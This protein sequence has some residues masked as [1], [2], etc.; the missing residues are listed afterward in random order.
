MSLLNKTR[1]LNRLLQKE[2]GNAVSFMDMAEVLRDIVIANIYV[3]SRKGKILGY[4]TTND[5]VS[6]EMNQAIL[7]ERRFPSESNN[8]LLKIEETTSTSEPSSP[9]YYYTEQMKD[10]FPYTHTT[11]VP[12]IGG[13]DRLGTLILSR[14]ESLFIDD[15]LILA[16]YG[17][18]VIAMEIL[19]E[20]AEEIEEEARSKAVVQVAIGSLSFSEMEAVEHIFEELDGKEG[21]LVASKIADRVGITRSVIV[22]ALRKLESAGVIETRSLGMKG[23]YIRILNEQLIQSIEQ[24]KTKL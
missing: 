19:R 12:I 22:N 21:L 10:M 11:L 23:T 7:L 16:E 1:R 5:P 3:V 4:A 13:G 24:I 9:Y 15:D 14:N 20:R 17:S 6:S 2:A 18:T 8:L